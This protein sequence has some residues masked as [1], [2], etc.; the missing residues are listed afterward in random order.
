MIVRA[1]FRWLSTLP[2][3][4]VNA[5]VERE[6]LFGD[7]RASFKKDVS[8]LQLEFLEAHLG[9]VQVQSS[10]LLPPLHSARCERVWPDIDRWDSY[11]Q[12]RVRGK[13]VLNDDACTPVRHF[14]QRDLLERLP[15]D[16]QAVQT[17]GRYPRIGIERDRG[18]H[19]AMEDRARD[20]AKSVCVLVE[21][22]TFFS[23]LA[24]RGYAERCSD[25]G[26]RP[27]S[28]NPRRGR[29]STDCL[30]ERGPR[31]GA[32]CSPECG[33][34]GGCAHHLRVGPRILPSGR[35]LALFHCSLPFLVGEIVPGA[36]A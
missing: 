26:Y 31:A 24:P 6:A 23:A 27:N 35:R 8:Y 28:L 20:H 17:K 4:A 29:L 9:G 16:M 11:G 5:P 36:A 34:E 32:M 14:Q 7:V 21:T 33:R 22:P 12:L 18:F 3:W 30:P 1:R 10:V 25:S 19:S 15:L 2:S 13:C